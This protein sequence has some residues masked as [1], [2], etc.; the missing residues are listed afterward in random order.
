MS[1]AEND[2]VV[3][4]ASLSPPPPP[5]SPPE[6]I[7]DIRADIAATRAELGD[8]V[9]AL[10]A[11]LDVKARAG[12]AL[13]EVRESIEDRAST[14]LRVLHDVPVA[15]VVIAVGGVVAAGLMLWRAFG[16]KR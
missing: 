14:G 2:D 5:P 16:G 12:K 9:A 13:H 3:H 15:V 10:T 4:G 6:D 8:T 11:K 7:D 1:T